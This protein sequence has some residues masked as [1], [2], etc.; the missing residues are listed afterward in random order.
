MLVDT[1][2]TFQ[3][4]AI[5]PWPGK[6]DN[7]QVDWVWGI[8]QIEGWLQQCVGSRH[9]QW[10]WDDCPITYNLG[11][12]FKWNRDKTLFILTWGT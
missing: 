4:H 10:A 7:L 9:H 1:H 6:P 5:V 12:A 3:Y 2:H 11:V 8:E